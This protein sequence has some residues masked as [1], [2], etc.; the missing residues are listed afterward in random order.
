M[1]FLCG[2]QFILK[3]P[4]IF[5]EIFLGIILGIRKNRR[6]RC[7]SQLLL[8]KTGL[9]RFKN[10]NPL[11]TQRIPINKKIRCEQQIFVLHFPN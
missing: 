10:K 1:T 11:L 5:F 6:I 3:K 2:F 9:I 8:P 4:K 7:R